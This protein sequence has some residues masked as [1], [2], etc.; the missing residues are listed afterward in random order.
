MAPGHRHRLL[1]S[2]VRLVEPGVCK[3][4]I[5][6]LRRRHRLTDMLAESAQTKCIRPRLLYLAMDPTRLISLITQ[7]SC[8]GMDQMHPTIQ[9]SRCQ[10]AGPTC[11]TTRPL[12]MHP[13]MDITPLVL[14]PRDRLRLMSC[15]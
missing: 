9:L 11:H 8:H 7:V 15:T 6:R 4:E 13:I 12:T 5:P 14:R 1:L 3:D 2:T 10:D